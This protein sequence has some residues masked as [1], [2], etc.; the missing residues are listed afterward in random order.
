MPMKFDSFYEFQDKLRYCMYFVWVD[1]L[2]E[3]LANDET[4]ETNLKEIGT[5]M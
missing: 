4:L 1:N 3:A 5:H 2:I